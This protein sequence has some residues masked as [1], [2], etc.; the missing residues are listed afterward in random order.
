LADH[1][2]DPWS[3]RPHWGTSLDLLGRFAPRRPTPSAGP[4]PAWLRASAGSTE[5]SDKSLRG[6]LPLYACHSTGERLW[7]GSSN[8]L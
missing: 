8:G 5:V 6:S 2:G 1:D 7:G 3:V 4:R